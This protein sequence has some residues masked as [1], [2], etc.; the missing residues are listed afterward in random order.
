MIQTI[1]TQL[2]PA[3]RAMGLAGY[4]G[5]GR[6]RRTVTTDNGE[7]SRRSALAIV[8][9]HDEGPG[10]PERSAHSRAL[11]AVLSRHWPRTGGGYWIGCQVTDRTYFWLRLPAAC[12]PRDDKATDE[13]L[14]AGYLLVR[15]WGVEE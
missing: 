6:T 3:G 2:L 4:G 5:T 11:C 14:G 9:G 8:D 7:I 13:I 10:A 15:F 1:T 12:A